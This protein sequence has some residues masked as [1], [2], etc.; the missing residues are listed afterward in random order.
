MPCIPDPDVPGA[1]KTYGTVHVAESPFVLHFP[2]IFP[3][4]LSE[5]DWERD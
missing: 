5:I 2:V 4:I 1:E 3:V